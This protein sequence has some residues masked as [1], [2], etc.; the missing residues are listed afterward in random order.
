MP[1]TGAR[2]V[3]GLNFTSRIDVSL[4]SGSSEAGHVSFFASAWSGKASAQT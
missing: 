1:G 4:K 3:D 2:G